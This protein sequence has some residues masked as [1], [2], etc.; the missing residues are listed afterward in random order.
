MSNTEDSRSEHSPMR[1]IL[2]NFGHMIRGRGFA[3]VMLLGVTAL[4]ARALGPAEFG[5][6][7]LTQTYVLLIRGLL[8]FKQFEAIVLYGAPLYDKGDMHTLR[9][10]ISICWRLDYRMSVIATVVA[11]ILA[12]VI[13]PLMGMDDNHVVL[14]AAYSLVLLTTG[15]RTAIGILRL[16]DQFDVLGKQMMIAPTISFIGVVLTWWFNGTLPVYIAILAFAFSVQELYLG[17]RGRRE[18]SRQIDSLQYIEKVNDAKVK[19]FSGLS[20]FLWITYWQSNVD[21]IPKHASVMMAG[22]LL[23]AADAGLLRLAREFSSLL[24]K[25][26]VFIRQVVYLDLTRSWNNGD[27]DFKSLTYH[28]ALL[29]GGL[30]MVFV[31]LG[32]FFGETLLATVLGEE[33]VSAAQLLT[34]L[35]FAA[36]FDLVASSLRSACYAI[37]YAGKVLRLYVLSVVIY[38]TL[39]VVLTLKMGLIGAGMAACVAAIL[40]AIVLAVLIHRSECCRVS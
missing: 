33:F 18:F 8:N 21:L 9:R 14:L 12:P 5:M 10:L 15:N 26:A 6:V 27:D 24:G 7:V 28:T 36:T 19:E 3:A 22:Y 40:P 29:G 39:F 16:F 32:Y 23:G 37:G 25:P 31:L 11:L 4:M 20:H 30:G 17:W 13:G 34:L 1:R 2:G 38:L 35:L